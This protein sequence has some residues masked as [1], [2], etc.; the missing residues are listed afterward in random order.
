MERIVAATYR[1]AGG[2]RFWL[3]QLLSS[4]FWLVGGGL[5][6]R[7]AEKTASP[8]AALF[9]L[10]FYLLLPFAVVASRSFQPDPL[11]VMLLLAG[12]LAILRYYEQPTSARLIAATGLSALAVL[13]KPVGLFALVGVFVSLGISRYGVRRA[14]ATPAFLLFSTAILLP[15]IAFYVYGVFISGFLRDQARSSFLPQLL[16][17]PFFWRGWLANIDRVVGLTPFIG[18]LVGVLLFAPGLPRNMVVGWWAGYAAFCLVFN[19]HIATHDYYHLQLVPI[20]ALS[21]GP[22]VAL[23]TRSLNDARDGS[24][25]RLAFWCIALLAL[26]LNLAATRFRLVNPGYKDRVRVSEQIG[27]HVKHSPNTVYLSSDYGLPL[28]YHGALSGRPWP[29]A[30]DL[31]WERLAGVPAPDAE[32]RFDSVF[33]RA[34]PQYF[35]VEDLEQLVQQPD[36]RRFLI[37][38]F[39]LVVRTD[40]FLIFKLEDR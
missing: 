23:I 28:E 3:P 19:Y 14:I 37:E 7:I 33:A 40:E 24:Y 1:L 36:L 2:E 13:V 17:D 34:A 22:I 38:R 27:E 18:A 15:T 25:L 30:S 12:S 9:S 5:L 35:I 32:R 4:I 11:M 31:E 21:L 6:Y 39:P 26:S 20:V 16:I 29:L 8:A 10:A